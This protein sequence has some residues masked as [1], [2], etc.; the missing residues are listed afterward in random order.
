MA[1]TRMQW[2]HTHR[3]GTS[4]KKSINGKVKVRDGKCL[5]SGFLKA[6]A[7]AGIAVL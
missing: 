5:E 7:E 2:I 1:V 4:S 6:E 3:C